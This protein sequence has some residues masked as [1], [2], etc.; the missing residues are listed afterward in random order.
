M[1]REYS[2]FYSQASAVLQRVEHTLR[3]LQFHPGEQ[4]DEVFAAQALSMCRSHCRAISL[5]LDADLFSESIN[6]CRSLFELCFDLL[7][8]N[9]TT[10]EA[11]RLAR[12]YKLEG[13]TYFHFS[14]E[15]KLF[16]VDVNSESPL[17]SRERLRQI[18]EW[19]EQAKQ[20]SPY[21]TA[22]TANGRVEFAHAPPLTERMG[23]QLRLQYY[24]IYRFMCLFTHPSPFL[25]DLYLQHTGRS[26]SPRELAEEPL[27]RVLSYTLL[28][29]EM[30]AG[31]AAKLMLP[32]AADRTSIVQRCYDELFEITER[33]NK[34]YFATAGH[35]RI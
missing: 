9:S 18:N 28:F 2:D 29:V 27:K 19:L 32:H 12:A 25:R 14:K 10:D 4:A 13:D 20:D 21:L 7:W 6:V 22:S 17:T 3:D 23:Q 1:L 11:E 33:A 24:H 35:K 26:E 30:V 31:N 8:I 34:G 16:E 5:L 15:V